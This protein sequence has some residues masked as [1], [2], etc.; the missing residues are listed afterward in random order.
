VRQTS[1]IRGT[2]S[3]PPTDPGRLADAELAAH[4]DGLY[5]RLDA[6]YA[7]CEQASDDA[8]RLRWEAAW[9]ALLGQYERAMDEARRRGLPVR[10]G[11]A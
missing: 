9:L 8:T 2:T 10:R 3:N 5:A 6:G 7:A 4:C 1:A 11:V